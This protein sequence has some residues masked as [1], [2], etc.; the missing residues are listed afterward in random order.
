MAE[1]IR[2]AVIGRGWRAQFFFKLAALMPDRLQVTGVM[3][4]SAQAAA[5]VAAQWRLPVVQDLDELLRTGDP[6]YVITSVPWEVNPGLVEA[7]VGR[8]LPVLSET[9]PAPDPAGLRALWDSVGAARQVQVAEQYLL[10]PDHAARLAVLRSGVIGTPTSAQV[11]STHG[12]HAVSMLRGMLGVGLDPASVQARAFTAPLADPL[13]PAGWRDDATPRPATTT[14]ATIDF[15]DG[16]SGLYDFTDNQ[17][18]NPLRSRRIVVR[19]SLGELVDDRVVRLLDHRPVESELRRRHSGRDLN[20]EGFDLDHVSFDGAVVYRNAYAGA[21]LSDEEI[22]IASILEAT[23]RW[24]RDEAEPPYPLADACQ[25]HLI[26][27]A[28]DESVRTGRTVPVGTEPW[29]A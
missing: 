13:V 26:S 23:G 24:C 21:R 1:P 2:Y 6:E 10:L 8:G 3:T 7:L 15:G 11:S 22:A 4:R 28:I 16:R 25:D 5:E 18:W 27:L 17:W 29:A 9:P 20:L 19:G 12:Y 14:L